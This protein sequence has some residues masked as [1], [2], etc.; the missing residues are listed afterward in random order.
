ME[1]GCSRDGEERLS[2]CAPSAGSKELPCSL[3]RPSAHSHFTAVNMHHC[4]VPPATALAVRSQPV[5]VGEAT[6]A[7]GLN[8]SLIASRVG[9]AI[10][11][12]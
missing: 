3:E 4:R 10:E 1:C 9:V 12:D 5:M 8:R 11:S 7:A 6:S 2:V